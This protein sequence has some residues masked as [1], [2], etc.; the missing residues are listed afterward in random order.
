MSV[1]RREALRQLGMGGVAVAAIPSWVEALTEQAAQHAHA[2]HAPAVAAAPVDWKPKVLTADQD[3]TVTTLS[4]LI[5]PATETPGAK[6][7]LVNRFVDA[8]LEDADDNVRKEFLRGLT[9]VDLKS[10]ELY[11]TDFRSATAQQQTDLL[12]AISDEKPAT[13]ADMLG[14][15]FFRAIKSMTITG[16]YTSEVGMK[17]ELGDDGQVFF[18]EFKGCDH[19]AH[20]APP[21]AKGVKPQPRASGS[22]ARG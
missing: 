6:A 7:A 9:W 21:P 1:S 15:D 3:A 8:V 12:T 22:T 20:G 13:S 4:E 14:R 16:Y 10:K 5:I 19:P 11:G 2:H 18:A 17:Q